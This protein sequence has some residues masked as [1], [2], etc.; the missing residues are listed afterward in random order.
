MLRL[1]F[2]EDM[3]QAEIGERI[4]VSQMQ[5]SRLIRQL[6]RRGCARRRTRSERIRSSIQARAD[7]EAATTASERERDDVSASWNELLHEL[8]VAMPGVQV[9]FGFLLAVPFAAALRGRPPRFQKDV[10]LVTLLAA[11]DAR[12]A[13]SRRWR[14]T[15]SSSSTTTRRT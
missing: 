5:V 15:G 4:G 11:R 6:A 14:I 7:A 1:R 10:Y 12:S 9:L 2:E 8:R 13:S 3:T